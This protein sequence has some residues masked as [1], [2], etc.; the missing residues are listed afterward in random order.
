M[1]VVP[2]E[3]RA[4]IFSIEIGLYSL[5]HK[6]PTDSEGWAETWSEG[7]VSGYAGHLV[8]GGSY[9]LQ[10]VRESVDKFIAS[11]LRVNSDAC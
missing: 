8:D 5:V 11:Y 3:N 2:I 9:V 6:A 1:H 4:H 7:L 10:W